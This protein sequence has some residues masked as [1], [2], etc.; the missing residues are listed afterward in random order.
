MT[1][2][3]L[4]TAAVDKRPTKF[5]DCVEW[6]RLLFQEYYYNTIA[7]LLHVFP[8]DHKT[9]TGQPFWSG[10]KRC[11]TPIKFDPNEVM[12]YSLVIVCT[13]YTLYRIFICSSL[14][15]VV[16]CM[17]RLTIS[18]QLKIKRK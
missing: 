4:K 7:Q 3:I 17:L 12:S 9:T 15:L 1:L 13:L 11:P 18:N 5:P 14:L 16:Y 10:P 8:P 2:R 6:A